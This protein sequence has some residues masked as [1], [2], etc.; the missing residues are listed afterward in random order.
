LP[1]SIV[2]AC[3]AAAAENEFHGYFSDQPAVPASIPALLQFPLTDG[4][5]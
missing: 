5:S 3:L 4:F 1:D 2:P